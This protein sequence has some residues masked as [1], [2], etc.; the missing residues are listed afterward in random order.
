MSDALSTISGQKDISRRSI[1][2]R[3]RL[4]S[5]ATKISIVTVCFNSAD[6]IEDTIRS[7]LS[8]QYS[9][10]EYIV[11][12]GG[13]TDGTLDILAR[14]RDR[15]AKCVSERDRG[16]YDAMNKGV[17]LAEGEFVGFLNADDV[18]AS[19]TVI[20]EIAAALQMD[21][22]DGVYGDLVYVGRR[23]TERVVRYWRGGEYRPGAFYSGWVPPH[24]TFFCRTALYRRFGGFNPDYRIAGDFELMLRFIE[25]EHIGVRYIPKPFVRMRVGGRAN[26]MR[27]VIRGNREIVRAFHSNGLTVPLRFFCLRFLRR[28]PQLLVRFP[29]HLRP[30]PQPD[31]VPL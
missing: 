4:K 30:S 26:T 27:G 17:R 23:D 21:H 19:P 11:V 3:P 18:Y 1:L 2:A 5:G 13:S 24:P 25:K 8:Q 31:H 15:I 14:Y 28:I 29:D 6:T 7:V 9:R 12:D 22:A 16:I 10:L 20:A